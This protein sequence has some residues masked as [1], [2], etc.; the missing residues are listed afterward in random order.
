MNTCIIL[1]GLPGSGKSTIAK[2][3]ASIPDFIVCSADDY[4]IDKATG[5]YK[6]DASLLGKAHDGC[7]RKF[8]EITTE[9]KYNVIV[10]NTNTRRSEFM[11]YEDM[12]NLAK[13]QVHIIRVETHLKDQELAARNVHKVPMETITR[14]RERLK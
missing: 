12:A 13:Y 2:L 9:G 4:F 8:C 5:V 11:R 10:D 7:Y 3:I 14:M 6:F 1:R